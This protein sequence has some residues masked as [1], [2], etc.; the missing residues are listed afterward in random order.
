MNDI[1]PRPIRRDPRP[2]TESEKERMRRREREKLRKKR[3]RNYE[4]RL[5]DDSEGD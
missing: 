4:K 1:D 5:A 2:T 3:L